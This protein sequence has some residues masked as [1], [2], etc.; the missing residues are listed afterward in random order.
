MP[1]KTLI[2]TVILFINLGCSHKKNL[3]IN[4]LEKYSYLIIH[5]LNKNII[6]NSTGFFVRQNNKLFLVTTYHTFTCFDTFSKE[7]YKE[8]W[9]SIAIKLY[10]ADNKVVFHPINIEPMKR[11]RQNE[12]FIDNPDIYI[13]EITP[14]PEDTQINSIENLTTLYSKANGE[15]QATIFYGYFKENKDTINPNTYSST[16]QIGKMKFSTITNLGIE[17]VNRIDTNIWAITPMAHHGESG[18]PV[19]FQYNKVNTLDTLVTFGGM[20]FGI[21]QVKKFTYILKPEI[22]INRIKQMAK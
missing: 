1:L 18:A 4:S 9:D 12:F 22:I 6:G 5:I 20:I 7:C 13:Y 17:E 16:R 2:I 11:T 3:D 14:I 10:T 19:F 8:E 21:D 15:P